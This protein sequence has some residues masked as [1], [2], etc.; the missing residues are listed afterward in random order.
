MYVEKFGLN[1]LSWSF[2][3]R[4]NV[5]HPCSLRLISIREIKLDVY[6]K[7]QTAKMKLLSSAF[8]SRYSKENICIC[9]E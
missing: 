6:G 8:S 1:F 2:V 3:I 5:L 4:V 9:S 7:P